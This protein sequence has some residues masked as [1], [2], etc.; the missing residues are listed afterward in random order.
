[1]NSS[2][3]FHLLRGAGCF[4]LLLLVMAC[5]SLHGSST[6]RSLT[7]QEQIPQPID[8]LLAPDKRE[9][10]GVEDQKQVQPKL[11]GE[12]VR[13]LVATEFGDLF[14]VD[15]QTFSPYYLVGDFNGDGF[16]DILVTVR[17]KH[18]L[19]PNDKSSPPFWFKQPGPVCPPKKKCIDDAA[20]TYTM[21]E[22]AGF[23]GG[24]MLTVIHGA[25]ELGWIN[26]Q[27]QQKFLITSA[28]NKYTK[29]IRVFRGKLPTAPIGDDPVIPPSPSADR[30][31][32]LLLDDKNTGTAVHWEGGDYHWY[33]VA[34]SPLK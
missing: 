31:T 32:I 33:P 2:T 13:A 14:Q 28:W 16:E 30:D 20:Y 27:P 9:T 25:P 23:R 10:H 6:R 34:V 21:G 17:L 3:S 12:Q 18:E 24:L 29:Y 26:S 8:A 1:M 11:N 7:D 15:D 4:V 22:L 5:Q 19:D